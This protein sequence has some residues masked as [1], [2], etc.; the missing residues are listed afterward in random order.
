MIFLGECDAI[1]TF[2]VY[3]HADNM[4]DKNKNRISKY[5]YSV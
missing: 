5:E 3:L 4:N 2:F 1:H